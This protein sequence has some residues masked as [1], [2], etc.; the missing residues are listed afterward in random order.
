MV[1]HFPSS[2]T[3]PRF[4]STAPPGAVNPCARSPLEDPVAKAMSGWV[5]AIVIGQI[6]VKTRQE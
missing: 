1:S 6:E 4:P 5:F 3:L 2:S